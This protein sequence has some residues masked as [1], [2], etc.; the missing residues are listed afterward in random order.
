MCGKCSGRVQRWTFSPTLLQNKELPLVQNSRRGWR[1]EGWGEPR[2]CHYPASS[3][4]QPQLARLLL[5]L[6]IFKG[7]D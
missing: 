2:L 3:A 1:P 6:F 5:T 7:L 4:S